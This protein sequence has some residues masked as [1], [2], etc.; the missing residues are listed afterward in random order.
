METSTQ[1]A[2]LEIMQGS[3]LDIERYG[4][5]I[6][7][8]YGAVRVYVRH[9][10]SNVS[11]ELEVILNRYTLTMRIGKR[12]YMIGNKYRCNTQGELDFLIR[13]GRCRI[14]FGN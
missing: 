11:V 2:D 13:C 10:G 1:E 3:T 12:K 4:F 14:L 8:E 6:D 7:R 9:F 5:S